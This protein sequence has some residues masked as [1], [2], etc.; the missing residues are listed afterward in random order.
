MLVAK[1]LNIQLAV[2]LSTRRASQF[3]LRAQCPDGAWRDFQLKPGRSEAW[4]TAYVGSRLLAV[5]ERWP[6]LEVDPCLQRAVS[7]LHV[8]RQPSGWSYNRQCGADSDTTAQVILFLRRMGEPVTLKGYAALAKFQVADGHFATFKNC[9]GRLGWERGHA[10]VTAVAMQAMGQ[11]LDAKHSILQRAENSLR[12]HLAGAHAA[13]SYWWPSRNYLARELL[14]LACAY[15]DAPRLIVRSIRATHDGSSFDRG[16]ALEVDKL[17]GRESEELLKPTE[18]LIHLQL[19]DGSWT[20][21]PILRVT[22][23]R[24][25]GFDDPLFKQSAVVADDLRTF[26]T[27][28]ILGALSLLCA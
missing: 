15:R 23:P 27:A 12:T 7:F 22:D 26:T 21:E 25:R 3:L 5:R 10:E 18:E 19:A 9:G 14:I 11:V 24:A 17:A 28:T 16:L 4:T 8:S 13:D 6:D 20:S 1:T 2:E